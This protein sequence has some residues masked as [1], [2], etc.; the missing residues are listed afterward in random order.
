MGHINFTPFPILET[1][2]L[3]LRR[4]EKPDA[5]YIFRLRSDETYCKF[6]GIKKYKDINEAIKY[7]DRLHKDIA[8]SECIL[9]SIDIKNTDEYIGGISLWNIKEEK[10]SEIGYDLL[11]EFR[12]EGYIQEAIK[13]VISYAFNELNFD[14]IVAEE[15]RTENI[16][17]MKILE[18]NGFKIIKKYEVVT[19]DGNKEERADY[20]L[21]R[22]EF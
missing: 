6:T 4:V 1:E 21:L 20:S 10:Q 3:L 9:W 5:K 14:K 11:P 7:I 13:A 2:R 16:K 12:G 17:S 8:S 15:V 19:K 18:G 22:N